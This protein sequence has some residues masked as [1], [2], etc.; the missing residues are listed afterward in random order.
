MKV[1]GTEIEGVFLIEGERHEDERGSTMSWEGYPRP[2]WMRTLLVGSPKV[3]TLRGL[4]YQETPHSEIKIVTCVVG[5]IFD[6]VVDARKESDTY[7]RV[8]CFNLFERS[9]LSLVIPEGVAHGY[10]TYA[11][12]M[13]HYMI[14]G[15]WAPEFA[16]GIV[17]N[18]PTLKIPWPEPNPIISDRDQNLPRFEP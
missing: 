10:Q 3:G 13:V 8:Q 16:R 5:A 7:G 1:T 9:P 11:P 2:R 4:H 17:W 12:S 14:E 15:D 6:V 18:D